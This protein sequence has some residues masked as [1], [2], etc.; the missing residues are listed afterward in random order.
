LGCFAELR[1]CLLVCSVLLKFAVL[2]LAVLLLTFSLPDCV[3]LE[4]LNTLERNDPDN[5]R[6]VA[7]CSIASSNKWR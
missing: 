7:T 5:K 2:L 1:V 3:Q 6:C 4:V